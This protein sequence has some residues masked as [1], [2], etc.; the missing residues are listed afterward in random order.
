M[1]SRITD[2]IASYAKEIGIRIIADPRVTV[3][4]LEDG[5]LGP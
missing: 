3:G 2:A 4:I 1:D 5:A